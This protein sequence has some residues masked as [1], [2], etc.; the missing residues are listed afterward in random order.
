VG[1]DGQHVQRI[2][3]QVQRKRNEMPLL[4]ASVRPSR[5]LHSKKTKLAPHKQTSPPSKPRRGRSSCQLPFLTSR[6]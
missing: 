5:L 1:G 4:E 2:A 6:V 3:A